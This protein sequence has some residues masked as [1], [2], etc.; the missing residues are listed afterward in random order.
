M[1]G[2]RARVL[3]AK[4]GRRRDGVRR[5]AW[6]I[7]ASSWDFSEV[8]AVATRSRSSGVDSGGAGDGAGFISELLRASQFRAAPLERLTAR[9]E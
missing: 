9:K 3:E 8:R 7:R 5:G 4:I 6:G 2:R 1:L